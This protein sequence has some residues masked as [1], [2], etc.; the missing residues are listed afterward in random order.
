MHGAQDGQKFIG[1]LIIFFSVISKNQIDNN[2][3]LWIVIVTCLTM[4]I[5]VSTG[6]KKIVKTL[7]NDLVYLER[8]SAIIS[9]FSTIFILFFSSFNGLPVSTSHIKTISILCSSDNKIK[10]NKFYY[11]GALW[12][13]TFPVCLATGY[14][15]MIVLKY[16]INL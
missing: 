7:G 5:G 13:I 1:L 16:F 10:N 8:K 12:I 14:A 9:D 4:F 3:L 2:I 11:I 6:G 15:F